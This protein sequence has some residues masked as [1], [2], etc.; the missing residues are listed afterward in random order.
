MI[1]SRF[2]LFGGYFELQIFLVF[3][4]HVER[5]IRQDLGDHAGVEAMAI[6]LSV[7]DMGKGVG[8]ASGKRAESTAMWTTYLEGKIS[9]NLIWKTWCQLLVYLW[10]SMIFYDILWY[11][12]IKYVYSM[13]NYLCILNDS[14]VDSNHHGI[15]L[16]CLK[17]PGFLHPRLTMTRWW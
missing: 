15:H 4:G 16:A 6:N 10:N 3:T 17:S 14:T 8:F 13:I 1:T 9:I 12:M 5:A 2:Y 11:S 7:P